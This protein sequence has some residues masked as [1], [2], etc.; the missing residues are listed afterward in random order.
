MLETKK[1][2]LR[3]IDF[4][5]NYVEDDETVIIPVSGGLDSDVTARLCCEALGKNRIKIFM[6]KE[7]NLE[8]KFIENARNLAQDLGIK[9]IEIELSGKSREIIEKLENA[10]NI[11]NSNS[12]LQTRKNKMFI[13]NDNYFSISR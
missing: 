5:N 13:K 12:A 1:E 9:L 4:I 11:F 2:V 3:I 7:E 10:D 6:V 8:N